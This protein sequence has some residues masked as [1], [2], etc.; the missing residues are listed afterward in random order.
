MLNQNTLIYYNYSTHTHIVLQNKKK[1]F[2]FGY[3]IIKLSRTAARPTNRELAAAT[4]G[5]PLMLS[6]LR[7]V[8]ESSRLGT[9][10][11]TFGA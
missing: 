10:A 5:D 9:P 11:Q 4:G 2:S 7:H 8:G 1:S 3:F 6:L